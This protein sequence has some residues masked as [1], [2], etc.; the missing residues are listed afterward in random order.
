M[1]INFEPVGLGDSTEIRVSYL[2]GCSPRVGVRPILVIRFDGACRTEDDGRY[3]LAIGKAGLTTWEPNGLIVD[4]T[5]L[6]CGK[7]VD[8]LTSL[9]YLGEGVFGTENL[10]QAVIVGPCCEQAIRSFFEPADVERR[11]EAMEGWFR[12]IRSATDFVEREAE[13]VSRK[14]SARVG[15]QSEKEDRGNNWPFAGAR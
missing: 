7:R 11:A 9:L 15:E 14:F 13:E 10:P 4:L 1:S 2:L 8:G 6:E 12:D 3:M 5:G